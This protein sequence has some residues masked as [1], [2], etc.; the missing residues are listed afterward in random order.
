MQKKGKEFKC[1]VGGGDFLRN[2]NGDLYMV[3]QILQLK[4]VVG[5]CPPY[6]L[7]NFPSNQLICLQEGDTI[8]SQFQNYPRWCLSWY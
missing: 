3:V 5:C 8:F 1:L 6:I 2:Q 4:V 7:I